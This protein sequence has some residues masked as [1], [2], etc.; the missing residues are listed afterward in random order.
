MSTLKFGTILKRKWII[1][2]PS[3]FRGYVSFQ[4]AYMFR[5]RDSHKPSFATSILGRDANPNHEPQH[6]LQS[7]LHPLHRPSAWFFS[8]IEAFDDFLERFL[9]TKTW[10]PMPFRHF[11]SKPW[12]PELG[13]D[14]KCQVVFRSLFQNEIKSSSSKPQK[15]GTISSLSLPRKFVEILPTF[16]EDLFIIY[17]HIPIPLP[18]KKNRNHS[19][20]KKIFVDEQQRPHHPIQPRLAPHK[21]PLEHQMNHHKNIVANPF[22]KKLERRQERFQLFTFLFLV[23]NHLKKTVGSH[24]NTE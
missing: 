17:L 15:H 11:K 6:P 16:C 10:K 8:W 23:G 24:A 14:S 2:E 9:V 5:L 1:F 18:P 4:G 22:P 13:W 3:V 20:A 19:A 7:P 12:K 21:T